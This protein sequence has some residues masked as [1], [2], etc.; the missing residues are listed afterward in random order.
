M[1]CGWVGAFLLIEGEIIQQ[2]V[3]KL[4]SC[5]IAYVGAAM[6]RPPTYRSNAFS[7]T[8]FLQGKRARASNARPYKRF[9]TVCYILVVSCSL[10]SGV[11]K[12]PVLSAFRLALDTGFP[13]LSILRI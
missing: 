1:F 13:A 12:L 10:C 6:G 5:L 3:N 11:T 9:S 4:H 8:V 7:G 2:T